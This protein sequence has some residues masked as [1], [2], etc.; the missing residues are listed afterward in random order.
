MESK[1]CGGT[2]EELPY[3]TYQERK[4]GEG[5]VYIL[6]T[7]HIQHILNIYCPL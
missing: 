4:Q 1:T 7:Q 5:V 2:R 6:Y 3:R